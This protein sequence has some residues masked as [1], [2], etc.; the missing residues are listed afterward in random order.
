[1]L[2][3]DRPRP[4]RVDAEISPTLSASPSQTTTSPNQVNNTSAPPSDSEPVEA[5]KS[6][7]HLQAA[8]RQEDNMRV[9]NRKITPIPAPNDLGK[10]TKPQTPEPT[11]TKV[12]PPPDTTSGSIY[13]EYPQ[14]QNI[15][16]S[17]MPMEIQ[18]GPI[19]PAVIT[20]TFYPSNKLWGVLAM[21]GFL[22][23]VL[24]ALLAILLVRKQSTGPTED[25]KLRR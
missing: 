12:K 19:N 23:V 1:M 14:Q 3:K 22:L 10:T 21:I 9:V 20:T 16:G 18:N 11:T 25:G 2:P 6:Q 5:S 13:Q 24:V 7:R 4:P 15:N 17:V 8:N